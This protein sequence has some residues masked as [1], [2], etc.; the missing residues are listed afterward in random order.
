MTGAQYARQSSLGQEIIDLDR[1]LARERDAEVLDFETIKELCERRRALSA[2]A[3][4][5][6][7]RP[8]T[9]GGG[10]PTVVSVKG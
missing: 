1:R 5:L 10:R 4:A 9:D 2:S 3:A 8:P 6:C 7:N